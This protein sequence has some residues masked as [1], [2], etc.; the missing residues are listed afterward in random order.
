MVDQNKEIKRIV[1]ESEMS[2]KGELEKL[3]RQY[4]ENYAKSK[5][6][7][8]KVQ[9]KYE[10]VIQGGIPPPQR[11]YKINSKAEKVIDET[12]KELTEQKIVRK[13]CRNDSAPTKFASTA[14]GKPTEMDGI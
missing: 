14:S 13:L 4:S 12:I 11:Q 8:G 7:C 9:S 10:H 1:S 6:D 5:N 2:K 3:L